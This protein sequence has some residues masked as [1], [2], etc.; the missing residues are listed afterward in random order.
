MIIF[1]QSSTNIDRFHELAEFDET[2]RSC[3]RRLAGHNERRRKS[4][5]E[6][7]GEGGPSS[8]TKGSNPNTQLERAANRSSQISYSGGNVSSIYKHFQLTWLKI[9]LNVAPSLL[10][11][12]IIMIIWS[13]NIGIT[14]QDFV[15]SKLGLETEGQ[16]YATYYVWIT[17]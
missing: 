13:L 15:C 9:W 2:K 16:I 3:R 7:Q 8:Q 10:S 17:D 14:N 12:I 5:S 6:S 1:I 4:S 11:S